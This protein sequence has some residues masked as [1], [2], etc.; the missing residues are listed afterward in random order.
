MELIAIGFPS[1]DH[2]A[3]WMTDSIRRGKWRFPPSRSGL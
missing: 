1:G 3:L 2:A